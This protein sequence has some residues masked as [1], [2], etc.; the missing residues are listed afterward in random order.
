MELLLVGVS[1]ETAPL[2]VRERLAIGSGDIPE[3]LTTLRSF[4]DGAVIL[5]TCNRTEVYCSVDGSGDS[6]VGSPLVSQALAPQA[7]KLG[8]F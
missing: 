1:H 8:I 3:S 7:K 6:S 4:V 2:E 5:S